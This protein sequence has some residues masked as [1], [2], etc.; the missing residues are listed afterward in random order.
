MRSPSPTTASTRSA[1]C[2][3]TRPSWSRSPRTR[4]SV[5]GGNVTVK[6]GHKATIRFNVTA[7]TPT[8]TSVVIEI[9]NKATG[10]TYITK[11]YANVT[12]NSDQTRSFKVNLKKGKYNIRIGATDAAGNVQAKRGGGTLTVK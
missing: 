8:A 1:S 7:V 3:P 5:T 12:T 4:P 9:R 6:K 10:K 2:R 11:R